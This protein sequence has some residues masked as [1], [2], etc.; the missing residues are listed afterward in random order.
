MSTTKTGY[1]Q[2]QAGESI[3]HGRY[4]IERLVGAGGMGLVYEA[5]Q[6][7]MKRSVAIKLLKASLV[8]EEQML[9]QFEQEA[10]SVSAL[11]HPNIV[12]I[13]TTGKPKGNSSW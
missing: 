4:V 10:L 3:D 1:N 12:T 5:T 9:K 6:S 7:S 2:R 13:L 8:S 11:R